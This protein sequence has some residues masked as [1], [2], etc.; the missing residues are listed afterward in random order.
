MGLAQQLAELKARVKAQQ[1]EIDSAHAIIFAIWGAMGRVDQ[2][3][4]DLEK[5]LSAL[6]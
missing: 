5:R 2:K 1:S 6:E 3:L 4:A